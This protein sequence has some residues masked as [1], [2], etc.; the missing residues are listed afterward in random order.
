MQCAVAYLD[1]LGVGALTQNQ[2]IISTHPKLPAKPV[3]S[4]MALAFYL[5]NSFYNAIGEMQK[6]YG[7]T[8]SILSDSAF[9]WSEDPLAVAKSVAHIN[10]KLIHSGVMCRSGL[11][12][13]D[14]ALDLNT[15]TGTQIVA[16]DAVSKAVALEK[17]G[18]GIRCFIDQDFPK[19]LPERIHK[20]YLSSQLFTPAYN[21][22]QFS[23]VDVF[24]W[25]LM[26]YM[27]DMSR[28]DNRCKTFIREKVFL[29][30]QRLLHSPLYSWNDCTP[31]GRTHLAG[32][33]SNLANSLDHFTN[34]NT[35]NIP[36][37][38]LLD[39]E[40]SR[41]EKG[42]RYAIKASVKHFRDTCGR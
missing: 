39:S 40:R 34:D 30:M 4:N 24:N 35:Y 23:V 27:C 31:S 28:C 22:A 26:P 29:A 32:T 18:K 8:F 5:M 10:H 19:C 11:T 12:Y 17:S 7:V 21:Y 42:Y 25:H 20:C 36:F 16:G 41:T 33:I 15:T 9:I 2:V 38:I 3:D 1:I 37:D 6:K 13:G 14:F